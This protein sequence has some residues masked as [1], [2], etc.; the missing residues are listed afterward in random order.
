[1]EENSGQFA[2]TARLLGADAVGRLQKSC[3]AVFGLG[4]VGS[5]AAEA[6]AR[7]GVGRLI[8]VDCD[9]VSESNLN[10]QLIALHS[11]LGLAKASVMAARVLDIH[12]AAVVTPYV[13]RYGSDTEAA[14]DLSGCDYIIDAVD[15]VTAK[16]ML[17]ERAKRE[18]IPI[19]CCMGTGNKLDAAAFRV[20]DI[21]KTDVCPLARVM[22]RELKARNITDVKVVY[23]TEPPT[24][25]E[26]GGR[27]PAS[28]PFVP[29]VAGMLLA[30]EAIKHIAGLKK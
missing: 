14:V 13:L 25:P 15:S 18:G 4:G 5:F 28:V 7:A 21:A 6:L 27:L 22:R 17:V 20:T 16:L 30:G 3:V 23:S 11:T 19:I 24:T 1:M 8:L 9:T 26:G 29:P 2:R 12:P 10:R